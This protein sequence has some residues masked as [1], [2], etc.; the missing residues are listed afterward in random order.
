MGMAMIYV[1]K[2]W[3]AIS[4]VLVLIFVSKY[5]TSDEQGYYFTIINIA[6]LALVF[7]LGLASVLA[8]AAAH[9]FVG[10]SWGGGGQALGKDVRGIIGL[11]RYAL[12]WYFVA[13]ILSLVVIFQSGGWYLSASVSGVNIHWL[14]PWTLLMVCSSIALPLTPLLAI[15]EGSGEVT[16]V[17]TVRFL[18]SLVGGG[19][20]LVLMYNGGGLY[21][22]AMPAL[23]AAIVGF[24][25]S[26]IRKKQ[27]LLQIFKDF[28]C[29]ESV[30]INLFDKQWRAAINWLAGYVMILMYVPLLFRVHG[31]AAAGQMAITMNVANMTVVIASAWVVQRMPLITTCIAEKRWMEADLFFGKAYM[32]SIFLYFAG[33]C[34][35]VLIRFILTYTDYNIRLL[36][37]AETVVLIIGMGFYHAASLLS[38]YLRAYMKEPLV[39]ISI[40]AASMTGVFALILAPRWGAYGIVWLILLVN[41]LFFFPATAFLCNKLRVKWQS[42]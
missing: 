2:L 14:G 7:E 39:T 6:S 20:G 22:A 29:G 1:S 23:G 32:V 12:K 37:L 28:S 21:A 36:T 16:E 40:I 3:Q 4:G 42:Q 18:Q 15:V 13:L 35:I 41:M 38:L 30:N 9:S 27:L 25:W 11:A 5:L 26:L 31:A 19:G 33:G 10:L 24:L 34:A 8:T 17:Y